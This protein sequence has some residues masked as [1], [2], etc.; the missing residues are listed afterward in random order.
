MSP[1]CA[2]AVLTMMAAETEPPRPCVDCVSDCDCPRCRKRKIPPTTRRITNATTTHTQW[3]RCLPDGGCQGTVGVF[4]ERAGSGVKS[5][6]FRSIGFRHSKNVETC[7][8]IH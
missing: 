4:S 2:V 7:F 3:R 1:F 6:I 8:A 5:D